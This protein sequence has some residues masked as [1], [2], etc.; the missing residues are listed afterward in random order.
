MPRR[1]ISAV[2]F[3]LGP[4]GVFFWNSSKA[5]SSGRESIESRSSLWEHEKG[6][7][8]SGLVFCRSRTVSSRQG[9]ATRAPGRQREYAAL[10]E[11]AR[12]GQLCAGAAARSLMH[13]SKASTR[14]P[15]VQHVHMHAELDAFTKQPT[16]RAASWK[17]M[18]AATR[19]QCVGSPQMHRC[20][21]QLPHGGDRQSTRSYSM[22]MFDATPP[23]NTER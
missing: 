13:A 10:E 16:A 19:V 22:L 1:S 5:S 3:D 4:H 2:S 21:A 20:V 12:I 8:V 23:A 14:T 18:V 9:D 6:M 11:A 7:S 15:I 17:K